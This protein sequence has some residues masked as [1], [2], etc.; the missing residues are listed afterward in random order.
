MLTT[1]KKTSSIDEQK[2][3]IIVRKKFNLILINDLL[4]YIDDVNLRK[5]LCILKFIKKK[6][7]DFA[8]DEN[9]YQKFQRIYDRVTTNYYMRHFIRKLKKYIFYCLDC[10]LNQTKKHKSYESF[11]LV[12]T[13][14]EIFH[15]LTINF[16]FVLS[17][18]KHEF[19]Y[20]MFITCKFS[21]KIIVF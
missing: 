17:K 5:R 20:M 14:F 3:F 2:N 9:N 11:R 15:T 21:K 13:I 19:D 18:Q 6:I 12:Q 4:Y 7:F 10:Q 1:K 16:V 8:H